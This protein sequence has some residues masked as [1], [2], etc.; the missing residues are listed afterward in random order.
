MGIGYR[1][2]L[3][4]K[5]RLGGIRGPIEA[6]FAEADQATNFI[7]YLDANGQPQ[8]FTYSGLGVGHRDPGVP[9]VENGT[10]RLRKE[11]VLHIGKIGDLAATR[12]NPPFIYATKDPE[13]GSIAVGA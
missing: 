4:A 10:L 3:I 2:T 5:T 12:A 6:S 13:P 11:A 9:K 7:A 1:Q 8:F